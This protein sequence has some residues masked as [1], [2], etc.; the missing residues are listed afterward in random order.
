MTFDCYGTLIDWEAGIRG[1]FRSLLER[2]GGA[3]SVDVGILFELYEEEE[4]RVEREEY[5]SYREVLA[6]TSRRVASRTGLKISERDAGFLAEDLPSWKPFEET[7]PALRKLG[8]NCKLG[9]LSNVDEDLLAGTLK[10]LFVPFDL[11]V[12]AEQVHSYKPG[13]AHFE[14]ARKIIGVE[15]TWV[16]V[17]GSFYHDVEPAVQLAVPVVWVNRKGLAL[18]ENIP[19][20]GVSS[21][22]VL[23]ELSRLF[24]F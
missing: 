15:S 3:R 17:A 9:I 21:V 6:E 14:R 12:T 11:I 24:G 5:R 22:R 19:R 4:K 8:A 16:H 1:A 23:G 2:T 20:G 7:N 18:P 10:H 13:R